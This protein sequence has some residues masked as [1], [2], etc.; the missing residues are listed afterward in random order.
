MDIEAVLA[1]ARE[2]LSR[3]SVFKAQEVKLP[4]I[5]TRLEKWCREGEEL[6]RARSVERARR[7]A[8]ESDDQLNAS[9]QRLQ[10]LLQEFVDARLQA[11]R[12]RSFAIVSGALGEVIGRLKQLAAEVE[13]LKAER[14]DK[15]SITVLP[16]VVHRNRAG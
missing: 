9:L 8:A 16:N 3:T 4:E 13:T 1:E 6:D 15:G 7:K 14:T 12:Q 10:T 2:T 5:E 11:E